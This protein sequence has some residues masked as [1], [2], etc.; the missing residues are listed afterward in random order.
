MI[1]KLG[2]ALEDQNIYVGCNA[3]KALGNM[4]EKAAIDKVITKILEFIER[5]DWPHPINGLE[6]LEKFFTSFTMMRE[7]ESDTVL[8]LLS[9]LDRNVLDSLKLIS[10]ELFMKIFLYTKS[11]AWLSITTRV[12]L[13]EGLGV[14]VAK[15]TIMVYGSTE[16]IKLQCSDGELVGQLFNA[17][18]EQAI[19]LDSPCMGPKKAD[20]VVDRKR[21]FL[22]T[23]HTV[24]D[25]DVGGKKRSFMCNLL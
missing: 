11:S 9:C 19:M 14:T 1:S 7:L 21:D 8:K 25:T 16:P 20:V 3:C 22:P 6:A 23:A 2:S 5:N 12:A 13:K 4:G 24:R 18:V 10:P 15:S 17:F